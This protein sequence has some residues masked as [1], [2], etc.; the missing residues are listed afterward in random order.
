MDLLVNKR[1]KQ[2]SY[3]S[4]YTTFPYYYH[5]LDKKY[6]QG[7]VAYLSDKT[8]YT[9]HTVKHGDTFD[10]LALKYYNNPTYYWIICSFNRIQDPFMTLKVGDTLKIPSMSNIEFEGE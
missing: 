7:T 6:V 9:I 5:I 3:L 4:R 1:Y 10:N 2:P 8:L